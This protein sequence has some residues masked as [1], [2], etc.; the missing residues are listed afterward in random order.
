MQ[1]PF[2]LLALIGNYFGTCPVVVLHNGQEVNGDVDS[3]LTRHGRGLHPLGIVVDHHKNAMFTLL[4]KGK[5]PMDVQGRTVPQ[6]TNWQ[7]LQL[8]FCFL[9]SLFYA[10]AR[11]TACLLAFD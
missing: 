5:F 7:R 9:S 3:T 10:L 6:L 2:E 8:C 4:A 1:R 11:F